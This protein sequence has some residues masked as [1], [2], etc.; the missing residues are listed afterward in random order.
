MGPQKGRFDG[1]SLPLGAHYRRVVS[2]RLLLNGLNEGNYG[3]GG[4]T[5]E[6]ELNPSFSPAS[7]RSLWYPLEGARPGLPCLEQLLPDAP[8]WGRL[9]AEKVF[10]DR[11]QH[12]RELIGE[13]DL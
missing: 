1:N 5:T 10:G 9:G 4:K 3:N 7:G 12:T 8:H 13:R 2:P 6:A 11:A